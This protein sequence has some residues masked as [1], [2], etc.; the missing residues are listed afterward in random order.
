MTVA[1]RFG[2]DKSEFNLG[3][4]QN[5]DEIVDNIKMCVGLRVLGVSVSNKTAILKKKLACRLWEIYLKVLVGSLYSYIGQWRTWHALV[6]TLVFY[7]NVR[8]V[9]S[10]LFQIKKLYNSAK[11]FLNVPLKFSRPIFFRVLQPLFVS[12]QWKRC[13][14]QGT[15]PP[16]RLVTNDPETMKHIG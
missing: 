6:D 1:K 12:L 16:A 11:L 14:S 2:E 9:G 15:T 4:A 10:V 13:H 3:F 7:M 8:I 5:D